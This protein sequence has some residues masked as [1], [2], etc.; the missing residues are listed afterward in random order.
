M[1][2]NVPYNNM[3]YCKTDEFG[4]EIPDEY[5]KTDVFQRGRVNGAGES[6]EVAYTNY[7]ETTV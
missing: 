5:P 7:A 2:Y 1:K 4:N 6:R 3:L